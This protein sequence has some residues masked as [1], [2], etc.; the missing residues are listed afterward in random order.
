MF[1]F[2]FEVKSINFQPLDFVKIHKRNGGICLHYS[3]LSIKK[4]VRERERERE[5]GREINGV[6]VNM[7]VLRKQIV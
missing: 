7:V 3:K 1:F 6:G 5:E 2:N 4:R